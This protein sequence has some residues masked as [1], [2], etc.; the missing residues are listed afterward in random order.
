[1]VQDDG[2]VG[3]DGLLVVFDDERVVCDAGIALVAALA[4]RLGIEAR[5]LSGWCGRGATGRALRT[6]AAR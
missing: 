5:S 1:M 6:R 3:L 4:E 2:V